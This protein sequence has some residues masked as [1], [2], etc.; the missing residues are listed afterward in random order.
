MIGSRLRLV[1][2]VA[3]LLAWCAPGWT[4]DDP[5]RALR[6][7]DPD[8]RRAALFELA[9]RPREELRERARTLVPRLQRLA[10]RADDVEIRARSLVVL[11]LADPEAALPLLVERLAE[12]PDARV[13]RAIVTAAGTL[14]VAETTQAL[15]RVAFQLE[16]LRAASLAAEALGHVDDEVARERLL[17]LLR[18]A[19]RWPVAAG[20]CLGLAE[21]RHVASVDA[22]VQHTRHVDPAV[23][24]A[25]VDALA[26]LCGVDHGTDP[27]AWRRW[28][29]EVRDGYEF[30]SAREAADRLREA[31]RG[32]V[33]DGTT[34]R[35]VPDGRSTHARFFGIE[36]RGR[37]VAFVIDYSQSMWGARREKAEAELVAAV[38]GLPR[39]RRFSVVLFNEDVWWFGDGPQ[40][41]LPQQKLDL[42]RYLPEQKTRSYTNIHDALTHALGLLGDGPDA[43]EDA[44]GVDEIV[45][46]S[47]GV[48][49]RGRI[50]DPE[51]LLD[52]IEELNRG[53]VVIHTVSLG[54][55]TPELLPELARRCG[56][57]HVAHP[58]P[59]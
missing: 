48:P 41:A 30:P 7:P 20:T 32:P 6:S 40:A 21:Q 1:A 28:W 2:V 50:R 10:E 54:D 46:L 27:A 45:L 55:E 47:D 39:D 9:D 16:D 43:R 35:S 24:A 14:P 15:A 36:L 29:D 52:A 42:V 44:P 11:A 5:Y 59:K 31:R 3:L 19:P 4:A 13:S 8:R 22:L 38:K 49:N 37:R 18:A 33:G 56:G 25:A 26:R 51:R 58:F 53:R 12:E 23:R 17:T 57:R 34:D